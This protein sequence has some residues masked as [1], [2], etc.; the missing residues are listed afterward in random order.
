MDTRVCVCNMWACVY[1]SAY[2]CLQWGMSFS[3]C[4][5]LCRLTHM[6]QYFTFVSHFAPGPVGPK[7]SQCRSRKSCSDCLLYPTCDCHRLD[8]CRP[9]HCRKGCYPKTHV[10]IKP[11]LLDTNVK[12]ASLYKGMYCGGAHMLNPSSRWGLKEED[13][14]HRCE[15]NP[16]CTH[17]TSVPHDAPGPGGVDCILYS[18]CPFPTRYATGTIPAPSFP[19]LALIASAATRLT[20]YQVPLPQV[21]CNHVRA[22]H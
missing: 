15:M 4:L 8:T 21:P 6:C 5:S 12:V 9:Y 3:Q 16:R 2:V 14:Q 19:T 1:V 17:F 18:A 10:L 20:H 11:K 7:G 22:V 13:C